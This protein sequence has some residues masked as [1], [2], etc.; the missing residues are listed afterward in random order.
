[1]DR[2]AKLCR[3]I[4]PNTRTRTQ[5]H[6][7]TVQEGDS[8]TSRAPQVHPETPREADVPAPAAPLKSGAD[9]PNLLRVPPSSATTATPASDQGSPVLRPPAGDEP[10]LAGAAEAIVDDVFSAAGE[11]LSAQDSKEFHC[12]L[13]RALSKEPESVAHQAPGTADEWGSSRCSSLL[14]PCSGSTHL[15]P[16]PL[17]W[18]TWG[19]PACC[20]LSFFSGNSEPC[21]FTSCKSPPYNPQS[22]AFAC[23]CVWDFF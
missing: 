12:A 1:M 8:N 19:V 5:S 9:S 14:P 22:L 11:V 23:I 18:E 3:V 17:L 6:Q 4:S 7:F 13:L 15:T 21:L 20:V 16:R 10:G 2:W